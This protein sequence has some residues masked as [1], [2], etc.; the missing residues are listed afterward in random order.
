MTKAVLPE[1]RF[2]VWN[3]RAVFHFLT[4]PLDR[5]AYVAQVMRSVRPNGHVIIATF[6][7]NGPEKCS[8]Y[9]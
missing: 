9:L 6:A 8:V 3:D 2:D 1:N 7:E 5:Q 4:E